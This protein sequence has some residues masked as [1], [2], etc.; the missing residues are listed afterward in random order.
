[1]IKQSI[2]LFFLGVVSISFF[3]LNFKGVSVYLHIDLGSKNLIVGAAEG[4]SHNAFAD[5]MDP[6][7]AVA[8]DILEP[9]FEGLEY[10]EYALGPF[11]LFTET[12]SS[13]R[14][15]RFS[16]SPDPEYVALEFPWLLIPGL[17]FGMAFWM[18]FKIRGD[19][20]KPSPQ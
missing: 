9:Y 13:F 12:C 17:L 6:Y 4:V 18:H 5:A 8:K 15:Y 14:P 2:I 20:Q 3:A 7:D 1:M 16:L 10:N 19:R 11:M